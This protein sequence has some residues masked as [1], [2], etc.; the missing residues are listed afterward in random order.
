M[1]EVRESRAHLNVPGYQAGNKISYVRNV[2]RKVKVTKYIKTLF[3]IML[4]EN[5]EVTEESSEV[6]AEEEYEEAQRLKREETERLKREEAER[7]KREEAKKVQEAERLRYVEE[8]IK[9]RKNMKNRVKARPLIMQ[10]DMINK[11]VCDYTQ[12]AKIINIKG[13][14]LEIQY[15][16]DDGTY[17]STAIVGPSTLSEP[18]DG[19]CSIEGGYK[20]LTTRKNRGKKNKRTRRVRYGRK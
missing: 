16:N 2:P 19:K 20:K 15:L 3:T 7:L 10:P 4:D 5:R 12:K 8:A 1:K 6:I 11:I 14:M 17:G 13:G 9:R 18:I